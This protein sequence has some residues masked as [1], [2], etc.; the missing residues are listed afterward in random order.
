[1]RIKRRQRALIPDPMMTTKR[2]QLVEVSPSKLYDEVDEDKDDKRFSIKSAKELKW[3]H[4]QTVWV[5][6][7]AATEQPSVNQSDNSRDQ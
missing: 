4:W 2:N 7:V 6:L 3:L 5:L 1:M